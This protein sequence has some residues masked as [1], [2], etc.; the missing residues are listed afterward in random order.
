MFLKKDSKIVILN[1]RNHVFI[2]VGHY[3]RTV[4]KLNGNMVIVV[5]G[6][7]YRNGGQFLY[8]N[9]YPPGNESIFSGPG[10]PSQIPGPK[11]S[12]GL[13]YLPTFTTQM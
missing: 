12:M 9:V 3:F 13:V 4:S 6:H 10:E 2:E 5:S 8:I 7:L 11:C 1:D